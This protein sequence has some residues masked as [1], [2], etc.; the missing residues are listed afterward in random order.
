[1]RLLIVEDNATIRRMIN[2]IVKDLA[3]EITECS[4]G[5]EA[6]AAYRESR[7]DWVLM[8]IK[9]KETDGLAATRQIRAAFPGANIVIVTNYDEAD[10]REAARDA[11][12][13]AYVV[14]EDLFALRE[15]LGK[16]ERKQSV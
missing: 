3:E 14:K 6:L 13:R 9:M 1:M 5:S 11:G 2:S 16:R 7:P 15:V 10:L 12:A 4:D 8:D